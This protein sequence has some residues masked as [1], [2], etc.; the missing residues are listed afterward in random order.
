MSLRIRLLPRAGRE[1]RQIFEWFDVIQAGLGERFVA[2]LEAVFQ[3]IRDYPWSAPV[4]RSGI[5]RS[6][7][8]TFRYSVFYMIGVNS[9]D[10]LAVVH[11]ADDPTKWPKRRR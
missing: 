9:I 8:R 2:E 6:V 10:V 11:Q 5:R 1:V 3:R 4:V 7:L